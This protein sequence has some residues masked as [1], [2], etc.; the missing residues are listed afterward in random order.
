MGERSDD[1]NRGRSNARGR[2]T[3]AH[4]ERVALELFVRDGFEETTVDAI[5]TAAEVSP[6]TFFHHF[7]TKHDV[8]WGDS[9]EELNRFGELLWAQKHEDL[10]DALRAAIVAHADQQPFGEVEILRLRVVRESGLHGEATARWEA[11]FI[12]LLA[13]WL[14]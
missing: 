3:R 11:A 9:F 6:R 8:L 10:R 1:P 13:S 4:V 12:G 2:R 7:R 14:A 5:A